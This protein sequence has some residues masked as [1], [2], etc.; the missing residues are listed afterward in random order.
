MQ[1]VGHRGARGEA[2]ENTL[3][4]IQHALNLGV[5]HFEVDIRL[6]K[7][8]EFF[9]MHDASLERTCANNRYLHEIDSEIIATIFANKDSNACYWKKNLFTQ[10]NSTTAIPS[11]T[12]AFKLVD[13]QQIEQACSFQLEIKSDKH[14]DSGA[15]VRK[16]VN[17]FPVQTVSALPCEIIFTSFDGD[18]IAALEEIA[19][20]LHTGIIACEE[21]DKALELAEK[22]ECTHCCLQ[23]ELVLSAD[24]SLKEKLQSTKI[25]ISTWT[26]NDPTLVNQLASNG[27]NSVITDVP[28]CF[29]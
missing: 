20:H 4:A 8:G 29:I 5:T 14:T 24:A 27:V 19:P 18:I 7:D 13:E 6:S 2:P 10:E 9:L 25:H 11:L 3:A 17:D 23:Y 16:I 21:P 1:L 28:S 15:I 12:A 22:L 26:V